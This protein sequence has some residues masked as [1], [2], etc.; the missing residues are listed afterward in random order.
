LITISTKT[1][2]LAGY[3]LPPDDVVLTKVAQTL[4]E[5]QKKQA[6]DNIGVAEATMPDSALSATSTNSV[7]NKVVK[8]ALDG[9]SDTTH[10]H[11]A[12]DV[13]AYSKEETY[14][15]IETNAALEE[16]SDTTHDHNAVYLR[17]DAKQ[18]LTSD[19]RAQVKSNL[20]YGF[21]RRT[22]D[23]QV[24]SLDKPTSSWTDTDGS[25]AKFYILSIHDGNTDDNYRRT[26]TIM[27]D[28][29]MCRLDEVITYYFPSVKIEGKYDTTFDFG[30]LTV[31]RLTDDQVRFTVCNNSA[32]NGKIHG[33][34][35]V[36]AYY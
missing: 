20:G 14:S 18:E 34:R 23:P 7:Q 8:A 30:Y 17:Y 2:Q 32:I 3:V 9:K 36:T 1:L 5:A 10:K 12:A 11:T 29:Y 15:K 31:E 13:G 28:W 26:V 27:V 25:K 21:L 33:I 24:W 16:K 6:R 22:T 35:C 4:T 19:Q